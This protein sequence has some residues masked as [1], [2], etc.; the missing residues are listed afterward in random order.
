MMQIA[1]KKMLSRILKAKENQKNHVEYA[2]F[3][4]GYR[5]PAKQASPERGPYH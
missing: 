2:I 5:G 3:K 1:F 4:K